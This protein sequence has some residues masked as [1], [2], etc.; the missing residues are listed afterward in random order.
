MPTTEVTLEVAHATLFRKC[1][2]TCRALRDI[3]AYA[4]GET[5]QLEWQNNQEVSRE[6]YRAVG[7]EEFRETVRIWRQFFSTDWERL[8]NS[9]LVVQAIEEQNLRPIEELVYIYDTTANIIGVL[10]RRLL[11]LLLRSH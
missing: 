1:Y 4:D 11:Q 7:L 9:N 3:N 2:Y 5:A 6:L 10:E 8:E